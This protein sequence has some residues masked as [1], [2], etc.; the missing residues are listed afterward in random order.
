MAPNG[1]TPRGGA[2]RALALALAAL[3]GAGLLA[4]CGGDGGSTTTAVPDK[5]A[6]AEILNRVLSR[7]L[8]VV[9]AYPRLLPLLRGAD[10]AMARRFRAQE[11]EHV[12]AILKALRGLGAKA[13]PEEEE[14]EVEDLKT[15]AD[16][17]GFVYE[18]EG[19]SI[20]GG[21]RAI[22]N[23]TAPWPRSLMGSIVAN[24]A[25]HQV[26]LRRALGAGPLGSIP[27]AFENGTAPPPGEK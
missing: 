3:L 12:D 23:L 26:L 2:R 27:E 10:A 24:Q 6:D 16:A 1:I 8:A 17:L 9:D 20:D 5:E 18:I 19:V 22:S 25:Q 15:R 4:G 21:L 13:E 14:I 11:Q 7:E